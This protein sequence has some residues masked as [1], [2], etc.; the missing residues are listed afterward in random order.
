MTSLARAVLLVLALCA[1]SLV[2]APQA[3]AGS[4]TVVFQPGQGTSVVDGRTVCVMGTSDQGAGTVICAGKAVYDALWAGT[5]CDSVGRYGCVHDGRIRAVRLRETGRPQR[6]WIEG[7]GG[8]LDVRRGQ[9]IKAGRISGK[10][11]EAGGF[12]FTNASGRGFKLTNAAYVA[13]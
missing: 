5:P 1:T 13:R 9:K 11:L 4:G 2:A 12:T 10:R 3:T 6:A 8:V 7:L